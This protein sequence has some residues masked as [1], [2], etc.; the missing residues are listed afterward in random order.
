VKVRDPYAVLGVPRDASVAEIKAIYRQLAKTFHPDVN[1]APGAE[2]RFKRITQAFLVLCDPERRASFDAA[3]V[4]RRSRRTNRRPR[5]EVTEIDVGLR[6]AGID[7]GCL[8]GAH[9]TVT[10]RPLFEDDDAAAPDAPAGLLPEP[11]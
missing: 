9:V 8:V 10:R 5:G 4:K 6:V 7:L 2:E 1:A 11:R 3:P